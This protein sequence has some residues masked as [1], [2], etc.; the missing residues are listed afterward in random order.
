MLK[1]Q[2]HNWIGYPIV[3]VIGVLSIPFLCCLSLFFLPTE[4]MRSEEI[5]EFMWLILVVFIDV[6]HVYSTM[7]R[8]YVD[9]P[10]IYKHKNLFFGLPL[11]LLLISILLHSVNNMLFWRCLAY[12]AVYHFIRQQYGFLKIYS[13]KNNYSVLKQRIDSFTIYAVTI[14]PVLFWHFSDNRKFTWF[15]KGDFFLFGDNP[16]MA[17]LI[18]AV[19][20]LVLTVYLFTEIR[21][22]LKTKRINVQKN[23]IVIGTALSWYIGIIYFNNDL[24]FT[25]LNIICHGIPY[26]ALVWIHGKK[27]NSTKGTSSL[28]HLIFGRFS[29]VLFLIPLFL[30]AYAEEGLWDAFVWNEHG[31][32]FFSIQHAS[33]DISR[34]ALN[35]IVPLL[36]LPQLFHYVIDGFIWKIKQ[37]KFEW[38]KILGL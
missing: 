28:L 7:Y 13:R 34:A 18:I 19:F 2:E 32:L 33:I 6:G 25:F 35:I 16:I 20:W 10:L 31:D 29:L 14:L 9:K 1:P 38:T 15:I 12:L 27:S 30:F 5:P 8:T 37:D 23:S 11:F 22:L 21:D 26:M 17:S 36:S 24:V 4:L 3:E